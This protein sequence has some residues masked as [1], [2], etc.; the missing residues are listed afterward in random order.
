MSKLGLFLLEK[1]KLLVEIGEILWGFQLV[2]MTTAE[3]FPIKARA[4]GTIFLVASESR[5]KTVSEQ[6]LG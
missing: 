2:F 6:S 1:S 5:S 4:T 3:R